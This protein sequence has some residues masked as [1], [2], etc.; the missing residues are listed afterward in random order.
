MTKERKRICLALA[1]VDAEDAIIKVIANRFSN[2]YEIAENVRSKEALISAIHKEKF[3]CLIV[4]EDLTGNIDLIDLF[5]TI[6][7]ENDNMQIIFL[8]NNRE[9]GDPFFIEL[10]VFNIYDFMILPDISLDDIFGFLRSPRK[11][12]DVLRYLPLR[13]ERTR[14][15]IIEANNIMK[16]PP[17]LSEDGDVDEIITVN[18]KKKEEPVHS[19]GYYGGK[20]KVE[21]IVQKQEQSIQNIVQKDTAEPL[22]IETASKVEV[23]D[24]LDDA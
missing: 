2:D 5:K 11:F 21:E 13:A 15:L 1:H 10:F 17:K 8:M 3:D 18:L 9:N 7:A 12:R 24:D 23:D 16:E 19:S 20:P 4:R 14:T 6:R 22:I